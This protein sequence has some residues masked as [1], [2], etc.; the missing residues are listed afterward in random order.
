M[1]RDRARRLLQQVGTEVIRDFFEGVRRAGARMEQV[2]DIIEAGG[3]AGRRG[4]GKPAGISDPTAAR[5]LAR[6]QRMADLE[7]ELASIEAEMQEAR[8]IIDGTGRALGGIYAEVLA[9]YYL[10]RLTWTQT[11]SGLGIPKSTAILHRDTACEWIDSVGTAHAK[12]GT[13]AA[14]Y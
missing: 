6:I 1:G 9:A 3:E 5:A 10:R 11:A 7:A 2:L 4:V 8:E 13:G 14:T 12:A